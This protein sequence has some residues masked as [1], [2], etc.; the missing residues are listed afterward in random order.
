MDGPLSLSFS[1]HRRPQPPSGEVA[2]AGA[3]LGRRNWG[4]GLVT[5]RQPLRP[6]EPLS[7]VLDDFSSGHLPARSKQLRRIN[8]TRRLLMSSFSVG[9][10]AHEPTQPDVLATAAPPASTRGDPGC[11]PLPADPRRLGVRPWSLRRRHRP[12]ARSHPKMYL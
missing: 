9:G 3:F 12:H 11:P 8:V 1:W 6:A 2:G 7:P 10:E 4:K 5:P